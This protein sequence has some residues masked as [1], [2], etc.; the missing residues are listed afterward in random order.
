MAPLSLNKHIIYVTSLPRAGST[1]LCQLLGQHPQVYS[2]GHS[3]PLRQV[4]NHL[5]GQLSDDPFLLS[6]LE[7]D[8]DVTYTRL[9]P[10]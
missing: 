1:L 3:S 8:F 7:V 2:L 10:Y 4:F 9:H 5:R 6:Q